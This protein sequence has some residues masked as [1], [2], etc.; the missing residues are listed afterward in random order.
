MREITRREMCVGLSAV[1]VAGRVVKAESPVAPDGVGILSQSRVYTLEQ[2]PV[3]K[4]A[5]GGESRDVLRGTLTTGE[6]IGV[7]ESQQPAGMKPNTPHTIQHTEVMV[8][9]EGTL[10]FEHDSKSEKVGPGGVIFVASGTLHTVRNA[11]EGV[12]K[13]CVVQVGGDT[14]G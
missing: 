13:Y 6:V 5:N 7:H 10:A 8:V 4:M 9:I 11:G 3:R 14:K 1:A 2:M 12:A